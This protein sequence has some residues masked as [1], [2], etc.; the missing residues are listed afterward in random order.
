M[1]TV[2]PVPPNTFNENFVES[3]Q[4]SSSYDKFFQAPKN[5]AQ[6]FLEYFLFSL[7]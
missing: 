7:E 2:S 1:R 3:L 6:Y 5:I 4:F